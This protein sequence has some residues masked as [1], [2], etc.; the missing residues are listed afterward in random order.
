[1][2]AQFP[3]ECSSKDVF[4]IGV[5]PA[6]ISGVLRPKVP[7]DAFGLLEKESL[8]TVSAWHSLHLYSRLHVFTFLYSVPK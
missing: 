2:P 8:T 7:A 5:T 4:N 6:V 1:M 3:L